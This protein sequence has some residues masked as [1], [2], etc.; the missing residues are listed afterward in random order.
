MRKL[1][2]S[3]LAFVLAAGIAGANAG[4]PATVAAINAAAAALD[5]AFERQSA[6]DIKRM[7]TA[8]HIAVTPY[9]ETPQT[10]AQQIA[11]LPEL[12]YKQTNTGEVKV[13]VLGPDAGMRT[14]TAR[15]DGTYKGKMIPPDVFVTSIMV[16]EDGQWREKLYQVTALQP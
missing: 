1:I 9:Y 3:V 4:E 13:V 16:R 10:A 8:D 2:L 15:L 12:K 7:T 11:S 5:D 6:E 14:F